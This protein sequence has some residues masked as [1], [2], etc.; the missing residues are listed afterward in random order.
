MNINRLAI[1]SQ[2]CFHRRL[3]ANRVKPNWCITGPT[4]P[5]GSTNQNWLYAKLLP[6]VVSI[7]P[8][9]CVHPC[10]LPG[11]QHYC[12]CSNG[13][14]SLPP[15]CHP[16]TRTTPSHPLPPVHPLIS[17]I[18]DITGPVKNL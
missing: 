10:R 8:V 16:P 17:A 1:D 11:T 13:R 6:M 12:L 9:V 15:A 3:F 4:G 14:D 5:L 2:V 7:Y 18:C